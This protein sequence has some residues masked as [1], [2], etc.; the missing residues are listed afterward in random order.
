M[1]E[2]LR[3]ILII[4]LA[5]ILSLLSGCSTEF[6]IVEY[7]IVTPPSTSITSTEAITTAST[8]EAPITT[9]TTEIVTTASTSPPVVT[10]IVT[11]LVSTTPP[12][13]TVTLEETT[14]S[15]VTTTIQTEEVV[16]EP[17]PPPVPEVRKQAGIEIGID[18]PN[19]S[20]PNSSIE[21]FN[22]LLKSYSGTSIA[23]GIYSLEDDSYLSFNKDAEFSSCSTIKVVY[24]LYCLEE[25]KK[26]NA[27][28]VDVLYY[29]YAKHHYKSNTASKSTIANLG[30]TEFTL[31]EVIYYTLY[32]SDNDAYLMLLDYF[33]F[34]GFN[35]YVSSLGSSTSLS[36]DMLYGHA[37]V[38][39]RAKE[40]KQIYSLYN[41]DSEVSEFF[42]E[43]LI[44]AKYGYI[45]EGLGYETA[46]KSGWSDKLGAAHD[47]AVVYSPNGEYLMIIL[48][49]KAK[50]EPQ[51]GLVKKLSIVLD[52]I[53]SSTY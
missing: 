20:I 34:D 37:S 10:E 46:H 31:K 24:S 38:D 1:R 49:Q 8:T 48:T 36:S 40:W 22:I 7:T 6:D 21:K 41:E 19:F 26:G 16:T 45:E 13:T 14:N 43:T 39:S 29:D 3:Q 53:W 17:P 12:A 15:S 5:P 18:N 51:K 32:V 27:S 44:D 30:R 42:K 28:L 50:T 23:W 35:E 33:G 25:V 9:S 11:E 2:K 4:S 52:E 47:C